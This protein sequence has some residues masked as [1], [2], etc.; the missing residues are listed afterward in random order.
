MSTSAQHTAD[1]IKKHRLHHFPPD[2]DSL[3][4]QAFETKT[5]TRSDFPK[6]RIEVTHHNLKSQNQ[7]NHN[8]KVTFKPVW[9]EPLCW[10]FDNIKWTCHYKDRPRQHHAKHYQITYHELTIAAIGATGAAFAH[11]YE[12]QT[13]INIVRTA[14]KH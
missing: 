2:E 8:K 4:T 11:E 9:W 14:H 1:Y 10:F 13:A 5:I 7:T 3:T 6:A 12:L